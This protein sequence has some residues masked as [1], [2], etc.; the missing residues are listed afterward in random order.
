[1]K[2]KTG[3]WLIFALWH[4]FCQALIELNETVL[5]GHWTK[6]SQSTCLASD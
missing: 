3:L 1:M 5:F 2:E 6:R 4:L